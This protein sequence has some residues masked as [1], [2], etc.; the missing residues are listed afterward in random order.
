MLDLGVR[1]AHA[2][3]EDEAADAT[4]AIDSHTLY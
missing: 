3:T 1:I 4:E 2:S